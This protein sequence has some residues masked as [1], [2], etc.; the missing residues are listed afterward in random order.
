MSATKAGALLL[1]G[2]SSVV[3]TR[4]AA[5]RAHT[6]TGRVTTDS[7][8]AIAGADIIVTIAPSAVSSSVKSA[9]DGRYLIVIPSESATGEYLLYVGALGRQSFRRRI[10]I[11]AAD[12]SASI[13]ARLS[14]AVATIT[15]VRVQARRARPA[16]SLGLDASA[17]VTADGLNRT[18]DGVVNALSPEM[19]GQFD[20][21][22]SLVPGL[23]ITGS[24]VSAFGLG[25]D[26][27]MT[28]V[29]GMSFGG[30]GLP[31]DLA[32]TT[33]FLT[34]P[35]D[36]T[37]GGFS[38][39]L[40]S[41]TVNRGTNIATRRSRITLDSPVLQ[42]GDPLGGRLGQEFTTLQL[43]NASSGAFVLDKYFYNYGIQ[44]SRQVARVSSLMDFDSEILGRSGISADS[45]VKLSE[46]L[47]QRGIPL[48]GRGATDRRTTTNAQFVARLDRSLPTPA[49]DVPPPTAWQALFGIDYSRSDAATLSATAFPSLT[50]SNDSR[51]GFVQGIFSKYLGAAGDFINETA[52]GVSYRS[53]RGTPSLELPSGVVQT[54][55][56]SPGGSVALGSLSF[57]GAGGLA[58]ETTSWAAEL[59]NQTDFLI[60][61]HASLPA[62][63]Y[64][65]SRFERYNHTISADRLGTFNFASLDALANDRPTSFTRSLNVPDRAGGQ[66][67]GA[68]ALG[69]SW[70]TRRLVLAGG[71][72]LDAN[73]FIGSP[74]F[75]PLLLS[76]FGTRN[77]APH[78]SIAFSPR[79][80]F[81]WYP[82]AETGPAMSFSPAFTTYRAGYQIR[83]GIGQFRSFLPTHLLAESIGATGLPGSTSQLICT[84]SG[85]PSPE[86]SAYLQDVG[87][88]PTQCE[89]DAGVFADTAA[90]VALV[91]R[92][93]APS[94]TWRATLGWTRTIAGNYLAIDGVYSLNLDQPSVADLNFSGQRQ[95]SLDQENGRPV[96]A[97]PSSIVTTTGATTATDSR[98][99][100]AVGRV[101]ER[102]S[103]LRSDARQIT[104]YAI[105]NLP[106]RLGLLTV[107]YTY[108]QARLQSR[109]FDGGAGT[110]PRDVEWSIQPYTP[111]H[112]IVLQGARG[113]RRG[114]IAITAAA[115]IASGLRYTPVVANDLNGDGVSGD[116][117]FIFDPR[118]AAD[119][120]LARGMSELMTS[121]TSSARECLSAQVNTIARR[122]SCVGP[123]SMGMNA[124]LFIPR[125]PGT[126]GRMQASLNFANPLGALD[127]LLH[128]G[129]DVRGW[130]SQPVVDGTLLRVRA[131]DPASRSFSYQVNPRF[132]S[133]L[134]GANAARS[135]FRITLDVRIEY[136]TSAEEQ[137]LEQFMRLS[138]ALIGTRAPGD[139]L[140]KR[141]MSSV[142][143]GLYRSLLRLGD[144]LA[145]SRVQAEQMQQRDRLI[146]ARLDT[147]YQSLADSLAALP[148][149]YDRR[150]ALRR[151][152][153]AHESAWT[154][155]YDE[156]PF[157]RQ[158]LTPGQIRLLPGALRAML[159]T[160]RFNG[161][162]FF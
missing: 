19:Q 145:L 91:N 48:F 38:G 161:R 77:D 132:G 11:P 155:I 128:G 162:F 144:S 104:V 131:F 28:N 71:A 61:R 160:P 30:T 97:R 149:A 67:L 62:K 126:N 84:G 72:R 27:N 45:A 146:G 99:S 94:R 111:R 113:F 43:G 57:G 121:G 70:S 22:A 16:R 46:I 102:R 133:A 139:S 119:A 134:T 32:A 95:F 108:S 68:A 69:G 58:R 1:I 9:A 115:R 147:I 103:D 130:G 96:Y 15:A 87:R 141:Y 148:E 138:P 85:T 143:S 35:W 157:L 73:V 154:A 54:A 39:A 40:A 89:G 81:N 34:S 31:R 80:G 136:G 6:I 107:G 117:A 116:R 83:G 129:A 47:S 158:L 142:F 76:S 100:H 114:A 52:V 112:Q 88:I 159:I 29:N 13:D 55:M 18:V 105:P 41:T 50:G 25:S 37:R 51:G 44:A 64:L 2:L 135:P 36:P 150:E 122:N 124:S 74:A 137:R 56:I 125:V 90:G 63:L 5:Q 151:V 24:G 127:R 10:T 82:T 120:Q 12:S 60:R 23:T 78:S 101:A 75:N 153:S 17:A 49:A 20:A 79:I 7:A 59:T 33:V 26:A 21:M 140:K 118:Q 14:A 66:W 42:T 65:Q 106:F 156:A 98:R 123:W 4:L 109:G 110:D 8:T 92:S 3:P 152:N 86:W 53:M 93:Y